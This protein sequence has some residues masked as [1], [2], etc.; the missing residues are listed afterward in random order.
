MKK[1][2]V[3]SAMRSS[4]PSP[5]NCNG[6]WLLA[7]PPL[8][9]RPSPSPFLAL[10][11]YSVSRLSCLRRRRL[12]LFRFLFLLRP[13]LLTRLSCYSFLMT[14]FWSA[15]PSSLVRLCSVPISVRLYFYY[16]CI[17]LLI[18]GFPYFSHTVGQYSHA[19]AL[20]ARYFGDAWQSGSAVFPYCPGVSTSYSLH[21]S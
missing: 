7:V 19:A 4:S 1:T 17:S 20:F 10:Q 14:T 16:S 2:L 11:H 12:L 9:I 21:Q 13:S 5:G 8:L 18:L 15:L 3:P 6:S